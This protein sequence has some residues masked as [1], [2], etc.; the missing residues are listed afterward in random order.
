MKFCFFLSLVLFI[1]SGN[2][3]L[4]EAQTPPEISSE[5][6][7]SEYAYYPD[8]QRLPYPP[9]LPYPHV[10]PSRKPKRVRYYPSPPDYYPPPG[11]YYPPPDHYPPPG[12]YPPEPY[13]PRGHFGEYF[14]ERGLY[15]YGLNLV[16]SKRC[17]EAIRV[18]RDFLSTYPYSSLADN[19]VYWTGECYYYM[20]NYHRA[21]REFQKVIDSY[22]RG[23]KV[24]DAML[25]K[26]Y[27]YL[28]LGQYERAFRTLEDLIY[29]Y[30]DSR[31]ARL[32]RIKL[33]EYRGGYG[34]PYFPPYYCDPCSP[35]MS[36]HQ[37]D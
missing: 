23:N 19:A 20:K 18:F 4:S 10:S 28:S 14:S 30:P 24:P 8:G 12:Y 13:Y 29:R 36:Y 35:Y 16:Y 21:L 9:T 11:D 7:H 32:A 33:S 26:G 1:V 15:N 27:S 3:S 25:K 22:P 5:N 2:L 37:L 6:P 17:R 34:R 31:P